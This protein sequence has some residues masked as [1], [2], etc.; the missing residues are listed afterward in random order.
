MRNALMF[1]I[2]AALLAGSTTLSAQS[3][4]RVPEFAIRILEEDRVFTHADLQGAFTLLS[5]WS[6]TCRVCVAELPRLEDA[7]VRF[8]ERLEILSISMD[9]DAETV[10]EFRRDR[11]PMPW[12]QAFIGVDS[13]VEAAFGVRGTPHLLLVAPDGRI[14][15]RSRDLIGERLIP[16]L[17]RVTADY[18]V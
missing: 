16:T 7:H 14:V 12:S 15:A 1:T 2:L 11:H 17:E 10:R 3:G 4:D 6:T 18:G 13:E 9:R 5:F 8:G